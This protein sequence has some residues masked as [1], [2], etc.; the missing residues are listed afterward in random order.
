MS[1]APFGDLVGRFMR[2]RLERT[3]FAVP[4][5]I[6]QGLPLPDAFQLQGQHECKVLSNYRG[7]VTGFKLG[8][9]D[10]K[11]LA[12]M[13]MPGPLRGP[14]FSAFTHSSPA[15]LRRRDFFVCAV[16]AE[17][18]VRVGK[19]IG[20]QPCLLEREELL[21]AIDG[22]MPAIEIADSRYSDYATAPATAIL[23]DA[24]FAGAFVPGAEAI[25]WKSIDL[26]SLPVRLRVNGSEV[27]T[28]TGGRVM[29]DPLQALNLLVQDLGRVGRKLRAGQVVSTG[30]CTPPYLAQ[31]GDDIEADFGVLGLVKLRLE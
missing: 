16:E 8:G 27:R 11:A 10:M 19:D 30:A 22:V 7:E 18:A 14:I 15:R 5:E 12:A 9:T 31:A 26:V 3:P 25:Q 24:G 17:I 28:G 13:G 4:E 20:G 23:A 21:A 1:Q 29:G 6:R 2:A